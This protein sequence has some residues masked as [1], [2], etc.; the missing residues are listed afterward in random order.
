MKRLAL[1]AALTLRAAEAAAQ[2]SP[3]RDVKVKSC[4]YADSVLGP[5]RDDYRAE[6]RGFHHKE[7]DST[8]LVSGVEQALPR[9]NISIKVPGQRPTLDPAA[10]LVFYLRGG[11]AQVVGALGRTPALTFLLNDSAT[12]L[13][14]ATA[15]GTFVGPKNAPVTLPLSA[16]LLV[17]DLVAVALAR[18]VVVDAEVVKVTLSPDER[19]AFR[20]IVRVA[21]CA[22]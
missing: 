10:Q 17:E 12:V 7:R 3:Y 8:Y 2:R 1:A 14:A 19:R 20:A 4:A 16:L 13:P 21:L 5:I 18:S 15:L 6:V 9:V 22:P 11:E